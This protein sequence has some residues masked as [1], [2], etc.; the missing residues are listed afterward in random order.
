[1]QFYLV[2]KQTILEVLTE[3][4][5]IVE[6]LIVQDCICILFEL[7]VPFI[8]RTYRTGGPS[9]VCNDQ[10]TAPPCTGYF[11]TQRAIYL[12]DD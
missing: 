12:L 9:E 11:L 6:I 3:T 10:S 7:C 4:C 5:G 1:M 2:P 8:R